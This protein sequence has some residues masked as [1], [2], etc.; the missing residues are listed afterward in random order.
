MRNIT[1]FGFTLAKNKDDRLHFSRRAGVFSLLH[2]SLSKELADFFHRSSDIR[3]GI[4][5]PLQVA[6]LRIHILAE[7]LEVKQRI[8]FRRAIITLV[9]EANL[10]TA[11]FFD[12]NQIR[13]VARKKQLRA[14]GGMNHIDD[15]LC[16]FSVKTQVKFIDDKRFPPFANIKQDNQKR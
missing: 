6:F 10:V 14:F 4:K 12:I 9:R 13:V 3:N 15:K 7:I 2:N 11:E 16:K 5:T 8:E 1:F